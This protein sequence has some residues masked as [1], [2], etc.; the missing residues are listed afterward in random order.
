MPA[1][2]I[3]MYNQYYYKNKILQQQLLQ[4]PQPCTQVLENINN[5][6]QERRWKKGMISSIEALIIVSIV[7][8]GIFFIAGSVG[9]LTPLVSYQ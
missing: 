7:I 9:L 2:P 8:G 5:C 1:P 4:K 3:G 6:F